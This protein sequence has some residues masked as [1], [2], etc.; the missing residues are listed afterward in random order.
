MADLLPNSNLVAQGKPILPVK[1]IQI[2]SPEEW[3]IFIEEWV[4]VRPSH[5]YLDIERLAGAGDW[6]VDVAGYVNDQTQPGYTWD[7]YQC[8]HYKDPLMPN[9]IWGELGK[10]IYHCYS[11]HF[12]VP[13]AYYF[14]APNGCGTSLSRLLA[15]PTKLKIDLIAAWKS[16]IQDHIT[17][18]G[19][20]EFT[21]PLQAYVE[22]FN[23]DIFQKIAVIQ[24]IAEHKAHPNHL[25]WF[26]GG[27]PPREVFDEASVPAAVQPTESVYVFQLLQAYSSAASAAFADPSVLSPPYQGHFKRARLN[28]HHAEQLRTLYRDSLPPGTFE[29]FQREIFDGVIN[30]CDDA[31]ENGY[32]RVRAVETQAAIVTVASN[33][34]K[35]VSLT[36]DRIGVCHQLCNQNELKWM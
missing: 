24:L 11:S 18:T 3:E 7:C 30:I 1:R 27:L 29:S 25:V 10:F 34:L 5:P 36:K 32:S 9:Q 23:F 4:S 13:R 21:G 14:V 16:H 15:K 17:K 2:F 19:P 35:D 28:F 20:V 6:G 12:P 31:H 33:P 22:N 8:K 26:G